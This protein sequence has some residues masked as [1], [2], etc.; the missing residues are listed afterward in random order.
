MVFGAPDRI[1]GIAHIGETGVDD[2]AAFLLGHSDGQLAVLS[3]AVRTATP[4]EAVIIGTNGTI[5]MDVFWRCQR[6]TLC[7]AGKEARTLDLPFQGT[8][9]NCE[10]AEVCRCLREG[11]IESD[12]MPLDESVRIMET[13]DK[14]RAQW[15]LRYPME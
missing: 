9:L 12:V 4:M 14:I 8:G 6:V 13:M 7:L 1:T 11:R 5:R 15:G 10:A 2:Q 3:S